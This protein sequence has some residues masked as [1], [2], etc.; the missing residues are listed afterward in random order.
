MATALLVAGLAACGA[1]PRAPAPLGE[2]AAIEAQVAADIAQRRFRAALATVEEELAYAPDDSGWL[3][4]KCGLLRRLGRE[5]EAL[6]IVLARRAQAPDDAALSYEAGELLFHLGEL[7]RARAEFEATA[8]LAPNDPRPFVA[9]AALDLSERPPALER[10]AARLA[11]WLDGAAT[12]ADAEFQQGWIDEQAGRLVEARR[13]YARAVERDPAHVA[14]LV[15][16]ARLAAAE[17]DLVL[18]R[19]DL[20]RARAAA[21]DDTARRAKVE[22]AVK[23]IDPVQR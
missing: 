19:R 9:L 11:P 7:A 12:H 4:Q 6:Q 22:A 17:G 13:R 10:A 5:R 21:G 18:A 14:A 15:N 1:S 20:E 2:R 23:A 8:A 16:G 3:D